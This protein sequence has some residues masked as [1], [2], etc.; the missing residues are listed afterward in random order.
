MLQAVELGSRARLSAH[1]LRDHLTKPV[2]AAPADV[3]WD[4]SAITPQWLT[5]ILCAD[6]ADA[7]VVAVQVEEASA[8]SSVRKRIAVT[9]NHAGE[10]A[11]LTT[12]FFAKTTPTILTRLT[13][14]PSAGQEAKFF[15]QVAPAVPIETPVH[16]YSAHDRVSGRSIHLFED[17]VA[18]RGASFCDYRTPFSRAQM[19][20]AVDLLALLHG[21]FCNSPRL[22]N[23]LAW[24]PTYEVFFHALAR[25]G[26]RSGHE[27]AL[28]E[29]RHLLP[30]EVFAAR[31]KLW[32]A[33]EAGLVAHGAG[34]R[35]IIHSDVH[36]GNWYVTGAGVLGLCDWQCI[37]QGHWARDL[38]YAISTMVDVPQRRAWE[39][40]LLVRYLAKL[41]HAGGPDVT[42]DEAWQHYREQLPGALLMWTPTLCHPPT[43][44]DMQPEAVSLEMIRRIT[45]AIGDLGVLQ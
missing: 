30:A 16:R 32:P 29:A 18:T 27:Q 28:L 6:V 1:T 31:D 22:L 10:S 33:A 35:V 23:E 7:C 15:A 21:Q 5:P 38:A 20:A 2:C 12:R 26:T 36:P 4:A 13:S 41:K 43:M 39:R 19:E 24:I 9:Y 44:P 42:F 25:T 14:G 3:P 37:A 8:G 45:T 34:A 11:G 17:L 40:E